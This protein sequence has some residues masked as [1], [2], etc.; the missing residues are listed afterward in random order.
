[1]RKSIYVFAFFFSVLIL[2][3]GCGYAVRGK[4]EL[5]FD[6]IALGRIENQTLEPKLQDK[7]NRALAETFNAYGV[8]LSSSAKYRIEAD[9]TKITLTALSE[10]E[11]TASEYEISIL[12]DFRLVDTEKSIANKIGVASPFR[13]AFTA[14]SPLENLTA[15]K[16]LAMER[17]LKNLAEE[18][19]RRI[20]Y[21]FPAKPGPDKK[22]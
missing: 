4:A 6:S 10:Q 19:A 15:Q 12:A 17:A 13:A 7:L 16:E 3:D 20:V 9:I 5:P 8:T 14:V 11:L 1:M 18:L 21:E 22:K 2:L